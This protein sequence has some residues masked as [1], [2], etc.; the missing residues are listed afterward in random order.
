MSVGICWERGGGI[1]RTIGA[2]WGPNTVKSKNIDF[3][4]VFNGFEGLL[5]K[6][7][8]LPIY[9]FF[10][11]G[12]GPWSEHPVLVSRC[13]GV[14]DYRCTGAPVHVLV[15][16]CQFWLTRVILY[17]CTGVL[18][19]RCTDVPMYQCTD[20]PM[21]QCIDIPVDHE[22]RPKEVCAHNVCSEAPA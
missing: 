7:R 9:V 3:P 10:S 5:K 8:T 14:L 18:E 16:R 6:K 11:S 22:S 21:Y 12:L 13:I 15:Y 2:A 1:Q 19:Y 17:R 4:M 20:V